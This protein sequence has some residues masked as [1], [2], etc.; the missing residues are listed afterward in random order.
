[1]GLFDFLNKKDKQKSHIINSNINTQN[2]T[3]SPNSISYYVM[4]NSKATCPEIETTPIPSK[5]YEKEKPKHAKFT[6]LMMKFLRK[7]VF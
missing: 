2:R 3:I 6:S 4:K 1:M 5:V 7:N